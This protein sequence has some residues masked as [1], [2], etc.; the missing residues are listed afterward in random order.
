MEIEIEE[1]EQE[2]NLYDDDVENF[3][4]DDDDIML[5]DDDEV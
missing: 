2:K 4:D 5:L 1:I 3:A